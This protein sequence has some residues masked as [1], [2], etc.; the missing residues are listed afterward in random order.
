MR[1]RG[2]NKPTKNPDPEPSSSEEDSDDEDIMADDEMQNSWGVQYC[3]TASAD[4]R[5][6][7][8]FATKHQFNAEINKEIPGFQLLDLAVSGTAA[9]TLALNAATGSDFTKALF[10]VGSYVGGDSCLQKFSTSSGSSNKLALPSFYADSTAAAQSQ[11][12]PFPYF[13]ECKSIPN[14]VRDDLED[15]CLQHLNRVLLHGM[16]MGRPYKAILF[17]YILG[18]CGGE[19]STRFLEKLG[20]LLQQFGVTAVV[21]EILTG[22]RVGPT[23]CMTTTMPDVFKAAVSHITLGKWLK[24]ALVLEPIP[25]KVQTGDIRL[26]GLST[27]WTYGPPGAMFKA[28]AQRIRDGAIEKRRKQVDQK[29][30]AS[31]KPEGVWPSKG[32]IIFLD[33]SRSPVIYGLH[34]RIL[35][36]LDNVKIIKLKSQKSKWNRSTVCTCLI[37]AANDWIHNQVRALQDSKFAFLDA[38]I[39]YILTTGSVEFRADDVLAHLGSNEVEDLARTA[40]KKLLEEEGTKTQKRPEALLNHAISTAIKNTCIGGD[41]VI[42]KKRRGYQRLE[43]THI[44]EDFFCCRGKQTP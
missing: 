42:Y 25:Q 35:P 43:Y 7:R 3:L 14:D 30:C 4:T 34:N 19:L 22:A 40:R 5:G 12:V 16:F 8:G 21:D 31:K 15:R 13:I 36:R 28:V 26:R 23:M 32:L 2:R 44:R 41:A 33:A 38:M 11:N 24:M 10:A 20:P 6:M 1:G 27:E 9:N 39:G 37:E 18:G 29:F 17:E